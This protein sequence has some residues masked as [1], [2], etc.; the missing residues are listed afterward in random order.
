MTFVMNDRFP[1]NDDTISLSARI[2][3]VVSVA[4]GVAGLF[5]IRCPSCQLPVAQRKTALTRCV[6]GRHCPK[7][8]T[9]LAAA[10]G[11]FLRGRYVL[12]LLGLLTRPALADPALWVAHGAHADVYLLGSIHLLKSGTA[13]EGPAIQRAFDTASQCWFEAVQPDDLGPM[14]AVVAEL[15]LD[16][17][18]P[19]AS[20]LSAADAKKLHRL[21]PENSPADQALERMRPWL[22]SV[23]LAVQPLEKAGY[24]GKYGPDHVLQDQARASGKSVGGLETMEQQ[25]RILAGMS[26]T[27]ALQL[28]HSTLQEAGEGPAFIDKAVASWLKGDFLTTAASLDKTMRKEA[29]GLFRLLTTDRNNAW[30]GRI[31][32]LLAGDQTTLITV[33]TGHLAGDGNLR[34]LLARHGVKFERVPDAPAH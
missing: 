34:D 9:D 16:P 17:T 30:A 13:W 20:H 25:G 22:A 11:R 6:P 23:V 10:P 29:P 12:A 27:F 3:F 8:G 28:L 5:G 2:F 24:D 15:G 18:H 7:C 4:F 14:Q 19:L 32:Q 26:D 1:T 31:E 33:G 21:I